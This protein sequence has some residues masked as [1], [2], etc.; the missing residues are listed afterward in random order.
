TSMIGR[1]GTPGAV[2]RSD[3]YFHQTPNGDCKCLVH[4]EAPAAGR[5]TRTEG[6][7]IRR[8]RARSRFMIRKENWLVGQISGGARGRWTRR[9]DSLYRGNVG[10]DKI[11]RP[12]SAW[13]V[14][15]QS[16]RLVPDRSA[17]AAIDGAP[18]IASELAAF[19][20]RGD[21]R[22]LHDILE[23]RVREFRNGS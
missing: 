6:I 5:Q 22:R 19:P 12:F 20:G 8:S 4:A 14:R 10:Y 2:N 9:L 18:A 7:S 13:H 16:V 17:D 21:S 1:C 15:Y 3:G 23:L 11:R